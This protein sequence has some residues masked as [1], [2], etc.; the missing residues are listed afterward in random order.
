M[1]TV[2]NDTVIS[3][4]TSVY[5]ATHYFGPVGYNS[6]HYMV[7]IWSHLVYPSGYQQPVALSIIAHIYDNNAY[8]SIYCRYLSG[9]LPHIA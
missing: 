1:D 2:T 5:L 7:F 3:R 4:M 8:N 6:Q 9:F